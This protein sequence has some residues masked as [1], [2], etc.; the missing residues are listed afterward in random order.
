MTDRFASAFVALALVFAASTAFA[1]GAEPP[2]DAATLKSRQLFDEAS[3]AAEEGRWG[4]ACQLFQQAHDLHSTGGTALQLGHCY[5]QVGKPDD[6]IRA[7]KFILDHKD[8]E[9]QAER[10]RI[11][12]ERVA[13]LA[14]PPPPAAP[15]PP[16]PHPG[17]RMAPAYAALTI[18]AAGLIV[19]GI[20]GGIAYS[21]AKDVKAQ[22]AQGGTLCPAGVRADADSANAK[23]WAANVAFGVG[24]AGAVT[25]AVLLLVR[26]GD[27]APAKAGRIDAGPTG[28]AVRF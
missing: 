4:A 28:V 10:I 25:G 22:C 24:I 27:P 19:G 14:P 11:A 20:E 2:P 12:E 21:E 3:A 5:E 1:Q 6:A 8:T 16:P 13:A 17:L 9:K 23:G 15:P 26:S 18:G 7:Y